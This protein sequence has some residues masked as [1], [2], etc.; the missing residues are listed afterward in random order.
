MV[1]TKKE[2]NKIPH[3]SE[4][5]MDLAEAYWVKFLMKNR[6]IKYQIYCLFALTFDLASIK[7][8]Y[9]LKWLNASRDFER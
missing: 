4:A 9:M 5:P 8:H 1:W 6:L 7:N 2:K 3:S